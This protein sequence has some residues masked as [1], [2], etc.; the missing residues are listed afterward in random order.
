M[1][2]DRFDNSGFDRGAAAWVEA[3]WRVCEGLL[4]ASWIPG[5]A[6][7]A[8]LLRMFGAK[9]GQGVVIKPRVRVKFPWTLRIGDHSWVGESAW[10]DNLDEV[11]IGAHCCL[12]QGVYLCT[13][14][15][16][17]DDDAFALETRPIRLEDH[18]WLGAY[19]R[20][21]PGVT[22]G[23]GA[24]LIMGAV[25]NADLAPWTVHGGVPAAP[26]RQRPGRDVAADD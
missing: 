24:V 16:R 13:G 4:F 7:R 12:S 20:V 5:S 10:I 17:W 6:W 15:H 19:G 22:C 18:C 8:A 21:A 2:L 23:Q 1:H 14:N 9:V 11:V 3:L 26:I 25:A